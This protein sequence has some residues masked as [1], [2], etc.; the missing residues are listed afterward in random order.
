MPE[1]SEYRKT[2]AERERRRLA[3]E[4]LKST[5]NP[6]YVA[7]RYGYPVETMRAA[8]EKIPKEQKPTRRSPAAARVHSTIKRA[9]ELI[10]ETLR[11]PR[12]PERE[13]GSDDDLGESNA[14]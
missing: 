14:D 7:L 13:P 5:R 4:L 2:Q 8:L 1:V 9:R 6:D 11:R 3:W 10:P 12:V